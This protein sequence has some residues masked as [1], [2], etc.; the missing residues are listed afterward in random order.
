MLKF[1]KVEVAVRIYK[2]SSILDCLDQYSYELLAFKH[3]LILREERLN[4]N[5]IG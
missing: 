4:L 5:T 1:R 3:L 2:H